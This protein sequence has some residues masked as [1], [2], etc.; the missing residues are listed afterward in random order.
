MPI[1]KL[2]TGPDCFGLQVRDH[3]QSPWAQRLLLLLLCA[4]GRICSARQLCI[5]QLLCSASRFY[6]IRSWPL[7]YQV[8]VSVLYS[9]LHD[10]GIPPLPIHPKES[11]KYSVCLKANVFFMSFVPSNFITEILFQR[12]IEQSNLNA[13][14]GLVSK[15]ECWWMDECF[16]FI[17]LFILLVEIQVDVYSQ[18]YII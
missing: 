17:L 9:S 3:T 18:K 12:E 15:S 5:I 10:Q 2:G 13:L 11:F 1:V 6:C 16:I 4:E 14:K 8:E 7:K